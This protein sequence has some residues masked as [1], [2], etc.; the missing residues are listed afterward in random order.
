MTLGLVFLGIGSLGVI[1]ATALELK[2][3]EPPYALMIKIFPWLIGLGGV[4]IGLGK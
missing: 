4:L 2:T 3:H 1:G